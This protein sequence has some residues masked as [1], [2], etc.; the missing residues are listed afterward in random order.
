MMLLAVL[1]MKLLGKKKLE[2][3]GK[4]KAFFSWL[5]MPMCA[6]IIF[7]IGGVR[8]KPLEIPVLFDTFHCFVAKRLIIGFVYAVL[9]F[10]HLHHFGFK[11][12]V[13]LCTRGGIVFSVFLTA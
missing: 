12:S 5:L 6:V 4:V 1:V 13:T 8:H 7:V 11:P 2:L 10:K 9:F 3:P